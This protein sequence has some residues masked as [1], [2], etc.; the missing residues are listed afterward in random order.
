[1]KKDFGLWILC[2]IFVGAPPAFAL[3]SSQITQLMSF[4]TIS[5]FE[6][7]FGPPVKLPFEMSKPE[8]SADKAEENARKF[9]DKFRMYKLNEKEF[10]KVTFF[11]DIIKQVLIELDP[12]QSINHFFQMD[13]PAQLLE[14]GSE[15]DVVLPIRT[16]AIPQKGVVLRMIQD[17]KLISVQI[18]KPWQS[19]FVSVP[20]QK[21]VK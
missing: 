17:H 4:K 10:L 15:S 12:P 21:I 3:D 8:L 11:Q 5:E 1:M 6:K 2:F 20:L 16:I 19:K 14:E 18:Q 9:K 13:E 7:A